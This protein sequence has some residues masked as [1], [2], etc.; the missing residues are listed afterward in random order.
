[1]NL[2]TAAITTLALLGAAVVVWAQEP[3]R[4][5][6]YRHWIDAD[7][8]CQDAREEVLIAESVGPVEL[9]R[10]GCRV[11]VG[12]WIDAYTGATLTTPGALDIDHMVPLAEAHRSGANRWTP[13]QRRDYA[14]DL[15]SP[16]TLI[17]VSARAN[18]SKG[19]KDPARWLPPDRSAHCWYVRTWQ[20]VKARYALAS[21][22]AELAAIARVRASC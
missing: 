21:D 22:D 8:D 13:E 14:N 1:M 2:R 5:S 9:D 4:R 19:D 18:R 20:A 16:D 17:A 6:L 3:Y 11:R 15:T 12:R 7:R 10:V